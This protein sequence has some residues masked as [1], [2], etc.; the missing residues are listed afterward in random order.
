M[1]V[2]IPDPIPVHILYWTAW[3]GPDGL[4]NFREDIYCR[5]LRLED[6]FYAKPPKPGSARRDQ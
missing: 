1:S 6:A 4:L 2:P 5:D 3:V